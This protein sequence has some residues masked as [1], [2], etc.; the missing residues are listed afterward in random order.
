M[1]AMRTFLS[2]SALLIALT[3]QLAITNVALAK[4]S[5]QLIEEGL[6]LR[7][8][9]QDQRAL[10][11]FQEA[12]RKTPTAQALAQIA[13]AEQALGRWVDA[14]MHLSEALRS[15]EAWI[16][17]RSAPL[18]RAL[19]AIRSR[20]ARVEV[21]G[22]PAGAKVL[23]NGKQVG[24][25][26]LSAPV[27]VAAGSTLVELHAEG[28]RPSSRTIELKAGAFGRETIELLPLPKPSPPPA[29]V[30]KPK[31][32]VDQRPA[33]SSPALTA[34]AQPARRS[35]LDLWA[36]AAAAGA[37]GGVI[38]GVVGVVVRAGHI[39]DYND[40]ALCLVNG[41]T[42]DENCGGRLDSANAA[43]AGAIGGFAAAGAFAIAS[44][45]LFYFDSKAQVALAPGPGEAG[46]RVHARF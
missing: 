46:L 8:R 23:I 40:D 41:L 22:A 15:K 2:L 27:Y 18:N 45:L 3:A 20:L 39:N 43:Q 33:E 13:L 29:V 31:Q 17:Q 26:P 1:S 34:K 42:R 7:E 24:A 44:G 21:L 36:W 30:N 5:K 28:H 32:R 35:S 38:G 12:Y 37:L 4:S 25:L 19:Q 16:T 6:D 14:Q 11:L 10:Q 9:G